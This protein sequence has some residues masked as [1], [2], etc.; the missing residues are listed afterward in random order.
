MKRLLIAAAIVAVGFTSVDQAQA[1]GRK[2]KAPKR[3]TALEAEPASAMDVNRD[4]IVTRR[5]WT[6][7]TAAFEARDGNHDGMLSGDE[8]SLDGGAAR[9]NQAA[10]RDSSTAS[11]PLF[12]DWTAHGF[13]SLDHN[14]DGR[15]AADEWHFERDSFLRADHNGDGVISR[16]E[17]LNEDMASLNAR[18]TP[19]NTAHTAVYRAG[20]AR[21]E[22]EGRAAGREDRER[23]QGWDLEGQRELEGADS[24]YDVSLGP[25][26]E[27]QAGYR[28]GFRRAYREGWEHP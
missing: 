16:A 21:G 20:Y 24:G 19:A 28:A 7:T 18:E 12:A 14:R 1:Q 27:Y 5:E 6:G 10:E 26:S 9:R 17:F 4:G 3:A 25:R 8:L 13:D 2:R 23:Q 22:I 11:S 15:I